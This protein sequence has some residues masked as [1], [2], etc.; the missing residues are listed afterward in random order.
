[1]GGPLPPHT[2]LLNYFFHRR[3]DLRFDAQRFEAIVGG[4]PAFPKNLALI[5]MPYSQGTSLFLNLVIFHELGHF[6]FEELGL[7][8][9]LSRDI[10]SVLKTLAEYESMSE[11]DLSWCRERLKYWSE[12]IYCDRFALGLIG[13]AYSFAYIELLDIIGTSDTDDVLEFYDTHPADA[14]RFKEHA[15]QLRDGGWWSLLDENTRTSYV[16]LIRKLAAMPETRYV[17]ESEEK[18]E[19]AEPVLAAF[20]KLK[21]KVAGLVA[22]TLRGRLRRFRSTLDREEINLVRIYVSHGVVPSTLVQERK[23]KSPD[24][25]A[26][27]NAAYL[28][29]LES[30]PELMWKIANQDDNRLTHRSKWAERV[31]MWTLKALED[32]SL[33]S[34]H[35]ELINGGSIEKGNH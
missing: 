11:P 14:C 25:I 9:H 26:L 31:E 27:I 12:E 16:D 10:D 7:E 18:P 24:A 8:K 28:F 3:A 17:Y 30:L 35:Q 34:D 1:M 20:L 23:E 2:L 13:P 22:D 21:P 33:L 4:S 15:D 5:G 32:L 6:A 19:L 29:Y